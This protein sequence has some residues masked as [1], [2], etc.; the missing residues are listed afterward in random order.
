MQGVGF[1]GRAHLPLCWLSRSS[2]HIS[3]AYCDRVTVTCDLHSKSPDSRLARAVRFHRHECCVMTLGHPNSASVSVSC[4]L[5]LKI[6]VP[7]D[8]F[9]RRIAWRLTLCESSSGVAAQLL[10]LI[11]ILHVRVLVADLLCLRRIPAKLLRISTG[12]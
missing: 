2:D 8:Q 6:Q 5:P 10:L 9:L 12:N 11:I 3:Q 1:T 4:N 7:A